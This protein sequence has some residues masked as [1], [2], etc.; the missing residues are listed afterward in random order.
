M[1]A[2]KCSALV[3]ISGGR[4]LVQAGIGVIGTEACMDLNFG[5]YM[6]LS[7]VMT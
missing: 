1:L 6:V 7:A 4:G 3:R 5:G 2:P